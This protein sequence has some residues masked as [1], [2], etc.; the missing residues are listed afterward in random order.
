MPCH[1]G[2]ISSFW[3]H[4]MAQE[5]APCLEAVRDIPGV[6][7]ARGPTYR[8]GNEVRTVIARRPKI[9]KIDA[10][11]F[12][13][14]ATSIVR[15]EVD[16]AQGCLLSR[17]CLHCIYYKLRHVWELAW[18][19]PRQNRALCVPRR[20][21]TIETRHFKNFEVLYTLDVNSTVQQ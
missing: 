3:Y 5:F 16:A 20:A 19:K 13:F 7:G 6:R 15:N 18:V 1:P 8:R 4:A 2:S 10:M 21:S 11:A 17:K 12:A 14:I 9:I